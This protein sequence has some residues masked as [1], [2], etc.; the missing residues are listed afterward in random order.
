MNCARRS[1]VCQ[2]QD[3]L[4]QGLWGQELLLRFRDD[5]RIFVNSPV[6][7][8]SILKAITE[9]MIDLG[10]KLNPSKTMM[11]NQTIS[12][13]IKQDKLSWLTKKQSHKNLQKHF[14]L[15]HLHARDYPNSGSLVVALSKYHKKLK[16]IKSKKRNAVNL[17]PVISVLTDIASN[18]PRVYPEV[19]AI[20]SELLCQGNEV[21]K[22]EEVIEKILSRFSKIPNTN[23][24]DIWL[25]RIS[26]ALRNDPI[27][28]E[29]L[30]SLVA[31]ADVKIWNSDWISCE[32]LKILVDPA[33]TINRDKIDQMPP[34]MSEEETELF[35][36]VY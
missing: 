17:I 22:K 1:K 30:C 15:I 23:Y 16:R 7:G 12:N 19:A 18:N 32:K 35:H 21:H 14:L 10:M 9:T 34:R 2:Y 25:Q 20:L 27:S 6:D 31:G 36:Y 4:V 11:S 13:S 5:Y 8:E 24:L 29:P 26:P 33:R 28:R 3:S